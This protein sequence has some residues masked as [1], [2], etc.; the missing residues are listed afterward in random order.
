[1]LD[2]KLK[3]LSKAKRTGIIITV[4]AAAAFTALLPAFRNEAAKN[5]QIYEIN[6]GINELETEGFIQ[7][8][9][10][11][12]Y[13]LF[14]N[15]MDKGSSRVYTYEDLYMDENVEEVEGQ[16]VWSEGTGNLT[17]KS[18]T[19]TEESNQSS[20]AVS[21]YSWKYEQ[22]IGEYAEA[23]VL[24]L[25]V[26]QIQ[27]AAEM[28]ESYLQEIGTN[29]DYYVVEKS[30]GSSI[31]NTSLPI[32][33]LLLPEQEGDM[34]NRPIISD[35]N[36]QYPYYVIMD[37]NEYGYL[38]NIKVKGTDADQLLKTVRSVE[39]SKSGRLLTERE[40]IENYAVYNDTL[41][42]VTKLL[43]VSQKKPANV[44]FV[45]AIT[46]TQFYQTIPTYFN[47]YD[48]VNPV[49]CLFLLGILA[50]TLLFA[51]GK[52][53]LLAGKRERKMPLEITVAAG[54]ILWL[55]STDLVAELIMNIAEG[56]F[57]EWL[58]DGLP[59]QL[60]L[61]MKEPLEIGFCFLILAV[62]FGIYFFFCLE[63]SDMIRDKKKYFEKRSLIW[64]FGAKVKKYFVGL[65]RN[66]KAEV[67]NAD[68]D[69][70]MT[71]LLRHLVFIN[72]VILATASLLWFFGIFVLVFYSLALYFICKKYLYK[73]QGQYGR[74]LKAA[75][76]IAEGKLDNTFEDDFGVFGSYKEALYDI[77]D[78]FKKAVDEEVKSQKMKTELITNVSHDLKTPLTAIITYIDLLKEENITDAQRKEYIDTLESKSLRLKVLI[79]DLFEVSKANSGNVKL[80]RV[81]VD[82]CHLLRQ[83]YL[84]QADKMEQ[85]GLQVRFL[86]PE[87]KTILYLDSEK[88]YRIFENL[89]TNII[90]YALPATRVFISLTKAVDE[91]GIRI[92]LK[93]ISAKEIVGNPQDLTERFVR[94]DASR[95][96]EGSGLGLAIA[97]SFTEI[98][99]GRF[100]IETDGDVFK[101]V[102]EWDFTLSS[103]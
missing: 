53:A 48:I 69:D 56:Y 71:K 86:V 68:L 28:C 65:Y 77:Q 27:Q 30:S 25:Y 4:L 24:G 45:Y 21:E 18:E 37:Y 9:I 66:F 67:V 100:R 75:N 39:S 58:D 95:N 16:S 40:E 51:L 50:V 23:S 8:L 5:R 57:R 20:K 62:S 74:L 82:I 13:A 31:K 36:A 79:E 96:T 47:Y 29:M 44:T 17:E 63:L 6:H 78:G 2:T 91:R 34:D 73:I 49:Y 89:Y 59:F 90:K 60:R 99:G 3:N 80:N 85:A 93:N 19:V 88:T 64:R 32:E 55:A 72:F 102:I 84:E 1:M 46:Q 42:K 38:Q 54:A 10:Q 76:S 103:L 12:N 70:D 33:N 81:P 26:N 92:E 7:M 14:K 94:G 15:V 101:A 22:L 52:P 83:A 41:Q 61:W 43:T 98:Q 11:S 97:R 35:I 87:E